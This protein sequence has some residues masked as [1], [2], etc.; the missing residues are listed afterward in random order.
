MAKHFGASH[1]WFALVLT[2]VLLAQGLDGINILCE[3]CR[4]RAQCEVFHNGC[5]ASCRNCQQQDS[6]GPVHSSQCRCMTS[7]SPPGQPDLHTKQPDLQPHP[8]RRLRILC[9]HGFR[10]NAHVFRGRNAGLI[11]RLSSIAELVCVDAPHTLPFLVKGSPQPP[12]PLVSAREGSQS[13]HEAEPHLR[14]S[15]PDAYQ[16]RKQSSGENGADRADS[17]GGCQQRRHPRRGWLVEPGQLAADRVSCIH[18]CLRVLQPPAVPYCLEQPGY[19]T[20]GFRLW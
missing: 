20:I 15:E 9:L 18:P 1:K 17:C 12:S 7:G 4:R 14:G 16:E 3:L 2:A 19:G 13:E 10:Q 8:G 6:G 11:R 5:T